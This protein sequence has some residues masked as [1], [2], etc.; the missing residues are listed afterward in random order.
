MTRKIVDEFEYVKKISEKM[1]EHD[2][3]EQDMRVEVTPEHSDRPS[4]YHIYGGNKAPM[5]AAF[6]IL[7][8]E[9]E[10]ELIL[11]T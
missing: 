11:R 9:E 6:A 4:G 8:V 10:F 1:K 3:Y 5:V 7:K 2:L